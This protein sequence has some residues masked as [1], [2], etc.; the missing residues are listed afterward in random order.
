[1]GD[2]QYERLSI[3]RLNLSVRAHNLLKRSGINTLGELVLAYKNGK[4]LEIRNLGIRIFDEI[5]EI[6]EDITGEDFQDGFTVPEEIENISIREIKLSERLRNVLIS[7]GVLTVG[8]L[9]RMKKRDLISIPGMGT[10]SVDELL[11][12]IE[13]IKKNGIVVFDEDEPV[14]NYKRALDI[15]TVKKLEENYGFKF[16]WLTEWYGVKRSQIQ[17][18]MRDAQDRGNWLNGD[19]TDSDKKLLLDMINSKKKCIVSED[20]TKAYFLNNRHDDCAVIF[21]SEREI[22]CVFLDKMPYDIQKKIRDERLDCLTFEECEI[23]SSGEKVSILKK[24][25]FRPKDILKFRWLAKI[26]RMTTE[27]YCK[28]LTGMKYTATP[29]SINDEK[30]I[31]FLNAHC[32]NGR[33]KI[34]PYNSAKWF[35]SLIAKYGYSIDEVA[36]LYGFRGARL[37]EDRVKKFGAIEGDMRQNKIQSDDYLERIFAENPLIG[38]AILPEDFKEQ[39]FRD[40]KYYI[41]KKLWHP[42]Y[43]FQIGAKMKIALAVITYAKEW[44]TDDES[45]FWGYIK[46][47]FGYRDEKNRL[48]GIICECVLGAMLSKRRCFIANA[49]E[50]QYKSTIVVHALT[51]K[52]SWMLLYDFLFDFYKTNM[53]WNYIEDD[54]II[55]RMVTALR[56]KFLE[57]DEKGDASIE[58]STKVYSFRDGI[59]KLIIYRTGYATHLIN[60]MLHRIDD[61]VNHTEAPAKLYVDVLCDQ[62]IENKL[63]SFSESEAKNREYVTAAARNTAIDYSRIRPVYVLKDETDIQI[64]FPDIRLKRTE[65]G[66]V[67][68]EV[69]VGNV[70]VDTRALSFYGNELGKTLNAFDVD[71]NTCLRKGDGT[72]NIRIVL[73][74]DEEKIFDSEDSMHRECLCF[75]S[76]KECY[77]RECVR[78]S[79]S[80]FSPRANILEFVSA[81]VSDIDTEYFRSAYFVRFGK[82]FLVRYDGQVVAFDK[83]DEASS[84]EIGIIYPF[85][86]TGVVFVKNGRR[87]DVVTEKASILL[88]L[89]DREKL[90]NYAVIMNS[91]KI[92]LNKAAFEETENSLIYTIPLIEKND[93]TCEFQVIDLDKDRVISQ[94]AVK[95]ISGFNVRFNRKYYFS[96]DDYR[97]AY[98]NI[99]SAK[100]LERYELSSNDEILSFPLDDGSVEIKIPRIIITDESGQEWKKMYSA[101]IKNIRQDAKIYLTAPDECDCALKL[102]IIDVAEEAKGCYGLGN[103]VLACSGEVEEGWVD[104]ILTVSAEKSIQKYVIGRISPIERFIEKVKFDYHDNTLYWNRGNGFIGNTSS[105]LWLKLQTSEGSK[106]YQL[107]LDDEIVVKNPNLPLKEYKFSIVKESENIFLGDETTLYEGTLFI[108]DKNELRFNN[109]IIEITNITFEEAENLRSVEIKNTYIDQ[110]EYQ[111]IQ[112]VGSENRECPV[113]RGVMFFM[114]HSMER[115]EFSFEEEMLQNGAQLYKINPVKIVFINE[116]TLSITS[117]DGDGIYYYRYLDRDEMQNYYYIT[118]RKPNVR[119]KDVYYLADLYTYNKERNKLNA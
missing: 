97:G 15:D 29:T 42:Q 40:A 89:K 95:I 69:Y 1:M 86:D 51:T 99:V 116:H 80:I 83:A 31:K 98:V 60:H 18:I 23:I 82:G 63:K 78:A 66:R 48:R 103:A 87:Y 43:E 84:G 7:G 35:R 110:I 32:I 10:R 46:A 59:R 75:S 3:G 74:C 12:I 44:D 73:T 117:E 8:N 112:F 30:I 104:I 20:G 79:Y 33:L 61:T 50:N 105:S 70:N 45:S 102:G 85:H 118:D 34:H 119:N 62:W 28:F 108:G 72:L 17:Q 49:T 109:S 39:L 94:C 101:W 24:E 76:S 14:D 11:D 47:Q 92:E 106:N 38:N 19:M 58:I 111:G 41:D 67:R 22:K 5:K 100:G 91:R 68:L 77:I 37:P 27:A 16:I 57:G 96:D 6:I 55:A 2:V 114:G 54:P 93:S 113:Y 56:N 71:V 52:R 81:E 4:L 36:A 9:L 25:Y 26:R 90:R 21:V 64:S 107:N 88:I 115:Y 53:K 65:F 13:E